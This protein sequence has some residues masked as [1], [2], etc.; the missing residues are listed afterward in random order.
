M[1]YSHNSNIKCRGFESIQYAINLNV[2]LF[3]M[4]LAILI[5]CFYRYIG[6]LNQ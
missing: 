6:S 1:Y 4:F 5:I 2:V 3:S